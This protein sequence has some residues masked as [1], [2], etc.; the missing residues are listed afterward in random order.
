MGGFFTKSIIGNAIA[1]GWRRKI[2]EPYA[3][4]FERLGGAFLGTAG[5]WDAGE[6]VRIGNRDYVF[7]VSQAAVKAAARGEQYLSSHEPMP[8]GTTPYVDKDGRP[9]LDK[10]GK[11]QPRMSLVLANRPNLFQWLWWGA[12]GNRQVAT[13]P[14]PGGTPQ[15]VPYGQLAQRGLNWPGKLTPREFSGLDPMKKKGFFGWVRGWRDYLQDWRQWN[16]SPSY[17]MPEAL[18]GLYVDGI[19]PTRGMSKEEANNVCQKW[20][21]DIGQTASL[22]LYKEMIIKRFR[23][24]GLNGVTGEILRE[25][26]MMYTKYDDGFEGGKGEWEGLGNFAE[27]W[28]KG[29]GKQLASFRG[30]IK[31]G[32]T[33]VEGWPQLGEAEGT[34]ED[35]G[36]KF[37]KWKLL[38]E[39]MK[40]ENREMSEKIAEE[41][42]G[43]RELGKSKKYLEE[44]QAYLEKH[45]TEKLREKLAASKE[46]Y[47]A[48]EI[49][50]AFK[51]TLYED[52]KNLRGGM[53]NPS[54]HVLEE[55]NP[56]QIIRLYNYL[57]I[58][59][60]LAST[61]FGQQ[62]RREYDVQEFQ[63]QTIFDTYTGGTK[64]KWGESESEQ[65]GL[66][67][68]GTLDTHETPIKYRSQSQI[69]KNHAGI[70]GFGWQNAGV[71]LG[72]GFNQEFG[73]DRNFW[74]TIAPIY[75]SKARRG[76]ALFNE[77]TG[78]VFD[79][80]LREKRDLK[81]VVGKYR[82]TIKAALYKGMRNGD[83]DHY[84]DIVFDAAN[85][86][87]V[88]GHAMHMQLNMHNYAEQNEGYKWDALRRT[89][90]VLPPA[91][92][93]SLPQYA[94]EGY[95][96]VGAYYVRKRL[97]KRYFLLQDALALKLAYKRAKDKDEKQGLYNSLL[98]LMRA[99]L[100]TTEKDDREY[101]KTLSGPSREKLELM[102]S[103]HWLSK[104]ETGIKPETMT[105]QLM[106]FFDKYPDAQI[107]FTQPSHH[108]DLQ[109]IPIPTA[110]QRTAS[111]PLN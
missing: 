3:N 17:S 63:D 45:Y 88:P 99:D 20:L 2:V 51:R 50:S 84:D 76:L 5:K 6:I 21:T 16:Y 8:V 61:F 23:S 68:S 64:N 12:T 14:V 86:L 41:L 1:M 82:Q 67:G 33:V 79:W 74:P 36:A 58:K 66:P 54:I 59:S 55:L 108:L 19:G 106:T 15:Q 105:L 103:R 94:I 43:L 46:G 44:R 11:V 34:Q 78:Q 95:P 53:G 73:F 52:F 89:M 42:A 60:T 109:P 77:R 70:A 7:H 75:L 48:K 40:K 80:A 72:G 56:V 93:L 100:E 25:A 30:R 110:A 4:F 32:K 101:L 38:Q 96:G 39:R 13:L 87:G 90:Y 69:F 85:K 65:F 91:L 104:A 57:Y 18:G 22:Q 81:Y 62:S 10:A 49:D 107:L 98:E 37:S 35:I 26:L 47:D 102:F 27:P 92:N 97:E 83:L 24:N 111:L 71:E 28:V 9:I 29:T 31:D